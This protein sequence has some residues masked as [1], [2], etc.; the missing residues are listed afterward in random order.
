MSTASMALLM[1]AL[2]CVGLVLLKRQ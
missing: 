2:A 1:A